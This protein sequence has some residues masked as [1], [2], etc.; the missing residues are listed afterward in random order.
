VSIETL[1]NTIFASARQGAFTVKPFPEHVKRIDVGEARFSDEKLTRFLG[2]RERTPFSVAINQ[3]VEY[4]KQNQC[5][6][7]QSHLASTS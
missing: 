7:K 3:T 5:G 6:T 4:F 2:S 1:L